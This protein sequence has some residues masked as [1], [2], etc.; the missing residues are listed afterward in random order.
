MF[1]AVT[2]KTAALSYQQTLYDA[3]NST[4]PITFLSATTP[5]LSNTVIVAVVHSCGR[6]LR[7]GFSQH[8]RSCVYLQPSSEWMR[9]Q[10]ALV[11]GEQTEHSEGGKIC[12]QC[13]GAQTR[14]TEHLFKP[15][16]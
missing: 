5:F 12:E 15:S 9:N 14:I 1:S 16:E 2:K 8:G 10:P 11:A 7:W 4:R 3:T 6:W 13:L